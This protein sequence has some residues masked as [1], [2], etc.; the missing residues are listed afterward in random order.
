[1]PPKPKMPA[2][3][4]TIKNVTTQLNMVPTSVCTFCFE[5]GATDEPD[6]PDASAPTGEPG[7]GEQPP[8]DGSQQEP[9]TAEEEAGNDAAQIN[10]AAG[11]TEQQG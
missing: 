11:T 10:G 9:G 7:A 3:K 4:A 1:M 5:P 8:S 6:N 2:I